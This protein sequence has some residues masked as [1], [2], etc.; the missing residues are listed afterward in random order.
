MSLINTVTQAVA[1]V[2]AAII[3][4]GALLGAVGFV[5]VEFARL[6]GRPDAA[7][8]ETVRVRFGSY[9]L[10]GMEFLIAAEIM[11][12]VFKPTLTDVAILGGIVIIR[13]VISF[14]LNRDIAASRTG[15]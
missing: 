2:G 4:W 7:A 11:Q 13:T 9:L 1:Y 10:L 5:R 3:V 14:F 6:R 15:S 8:N 12:T